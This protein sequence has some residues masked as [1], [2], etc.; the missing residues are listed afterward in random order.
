MSKTSAALSMVNSLKFGNANR[1]LICRNNK[2]ISFSQRLKIFLYKG[3]SDSS[4]NNNYFLLRKKTRIIIMNH[5]MKT[6]VF[7]FVV[8][9]A[10]IM[11]LFLIPANINNFS[12]FS[13]YI[14]TSSN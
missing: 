9:Y 6:I 14:T 3:G 11:T 4:R 5:K 10:F 7:K 12:S 1:I 2:K 8:D 13:C